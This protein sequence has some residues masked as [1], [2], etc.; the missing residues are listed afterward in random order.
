M[1]PELCCVHGLPPWRAREEGAGAA[2][3]PEPVLKV[4]GRE[5]VHQPLRVAPRRRGPASQPNMPILDPSV[6][7]AS[8]RLLK[9]FRGCGHTSRAPTEGRAWWGGSS[10]S[11]IQTG[12]C[13]NT[14]T[15][16]L[17]GAAAPGTQAEGAVV[18][19][20]AKT[21]HPALKDFARPR[22]S[23]CSGWASGGQRCF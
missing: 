6:R 7:L 19:A 16:R 20:L 17:W 11:S 18:G 10:G 4:H 5:Q 23:C 21:E 13:P 12:M 22:E 14:G 15:G 2:R 3:W 1:T 9:G 8:M